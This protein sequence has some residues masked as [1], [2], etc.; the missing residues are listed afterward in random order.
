MKYAKKLVGLLLALVMVFAMS[1][2]AFA[3]NGTNSNDG[4]IT[5]DNAVVGET[6]TIYQILT[7]ESYDTEAGAYSYKATKDWEAFAA[8]E[9]VKDV[10]LKTDAQG[11]VTWVG[12]QTAE[13][14]S[15]FAALAKAYAANKTPAASKEA[16]AET[17]EF[18][19]LNLGYYL[20]DSSLGTLCSL[21]TASKEVT[22]RKRTASLPTRKRFRRIRPATMAP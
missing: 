17:V 16:T 18:T 15:A 22:L 11:Y 10:Y 2:T 20:L 5:I 21:D 8:Q 3:A 14:V 9:G 1:V 13:R 6:Y 19:G 7:L 12:D 4:K